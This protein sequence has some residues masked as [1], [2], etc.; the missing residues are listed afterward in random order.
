MIVGNRFFIAIHGLK[1][2]LVP[3][4]ASEV[5]SNIA[6]GHQSCK[7]GGDIK[8]V[9]INIKLKKTSISWVWRLKNWTTVCT[10]VR[11]K[12]LEHT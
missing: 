1:D 11:A 5:L 7:I 12:R 6:H 9:E 3:C 2:V 10:D 8:S 4:L